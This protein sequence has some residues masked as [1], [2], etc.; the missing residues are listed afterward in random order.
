VTFFFDSV[1]CLINDSRL[2]AIVF[3]FASNC[4]VWEFVV[5][6][7][8]NSHEFAFIVVATVSFFSSRRDSS[9]EVR[10]HRTGIVP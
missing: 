3:S 5:L 10:N 7:L 1:K 8:A 2:E 6:V 9:F 4:W